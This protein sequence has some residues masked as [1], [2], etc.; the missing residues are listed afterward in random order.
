[1]QQRALIEPRV[2]VL[3]VF[4]HLLL[5]RPSLT[6]MYSSMQTKEAQDEDSRVRKTCM[7]AICLSAATSSTMSLSYHE[8]TLQRQHI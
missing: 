1:M 7:E 2:L 5:C 3:Y 8:N 6:G 4:P